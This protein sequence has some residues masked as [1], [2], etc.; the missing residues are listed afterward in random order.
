LENKFDVDQR[1]NMGETSIFNACRIYRSSALKLLI[2][3]NCDVNILNINGLN[4]LNIA[5]NSENYSCISFQKNFSFINI[6]LTTRPMKWSLSISITDI[7]T[8]V[9]VYQK[10]NNFFKL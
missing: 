8:T 5:F 1:D 4:G 2:E 3:W 9:I 7:H 10:L 6:T